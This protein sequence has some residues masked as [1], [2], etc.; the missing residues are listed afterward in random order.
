[1]LSE[2]EENPQVTQRQLSQRAGIALGLTNVMLRNLVQK[3]YVRATQAGWKR[4]L[5]NLTPEGFSHKLRLTLGY[6][7]RVL[8]HYKTVRHT[9]R[10][11]LAPLSLNAESRVAI[12]G[13]GEFAEL[14]YLGLRDLGIEEIEIFDQ[15]HANGARFLAMPVGDLAS[16][17]PE[18]YDGVVLAILGDAEKNLTKLTE[19][20]VDRAKLVAFFL[21]GKG[22]MGA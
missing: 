15:N 4:W 20:G 6:V 8:D 13:T 19:H 21:D 18:R 14:V 1:M 2:V 7:H 11:Q 17:E 12:Y 5:Y 10:E 3:G 22:R 9:L 16:L